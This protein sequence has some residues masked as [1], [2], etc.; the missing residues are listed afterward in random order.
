MAYSR[1]PKRKSYKKKKPLAAARFSKTKRDALVKKMRQVAK[2]VV[3][4]NIETKVAT[5]TSVDGIEIFHNLFVTLDSTLLATAQ[6]V[7]DNDGVNMISNRVGDE[8]NLRGV[9]L[10]MMIELNERYS[11][12]THRLLVVKAA[13]GDTPTR[14]TLFNGLSGNKMLD[15]INTERYTVVAQKWFKIKA[16]GQSMPDPVTGAGGVGSGIAY[17]SAGNAVHFAASRA[18]KIVKLWIPGSKI[19]RGPLKYDDQ[20]TQVKFFDYHVLLYA[21]SNYST[22]QDTYY[23][24]RVNDYIKQMYFKDA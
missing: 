3:N 24:S 14:T 23:V 1:Y 19:T 18:T 8:V 13:R 7:T 17:Q 22:L 10:K 11:D 16:A 5:H 2:S 21:Y 20:S 6:G 9:S 12:V 4:K 15:S